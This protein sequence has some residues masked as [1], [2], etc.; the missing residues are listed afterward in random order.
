MLDIIRIWWMKITTPEVIFFCKKDVRESS[1]ALYSIYGARIMNELVLIQ[2]AM[3]HWSFGMVH[4]LDIEN[5]ITGLR[6]DKRA[7]ICSVLSNPWW[8]TSQIF[9]KT[10]IHIRIKSY[11]LKWSF[12]QVWFNSNMDDG[13]IKYLASIS[14]WIR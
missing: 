2:C 5:E 6:W 12:Q 1:E 14:S 7:Q 11:L 8:Y 3:I 13:F 4:L 9:D 10:I